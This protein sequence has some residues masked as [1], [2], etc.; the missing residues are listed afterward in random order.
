MGKFK[1]AKF[2]ITILI[3]SIV[4]V[5]I[6]SQ[7][8][9]DEGVG[10]IIPA[11]EL[12]VVGGCFRDCLD[13][14]QTGFGT[15]DC[16]EGTIA[17]EGMCVELIEATLTTFNDDGT[18]T[19]TQVLVNADG[20][21]IDPTAPTPTAPTPTEPTPTPTGEQTIT[22]NDQVF[23]V[24]Q[25]T[26]PIACWISVDADIIGEKGLVLDTEKSDVLKFA[27]RATLSLVDQPTGLPILDQGGF[28][29]ML[30]I[31][32]STNMESG[33]LDP[34]GDL[35]NFFNVFNYPSFDTALRL[36]PTKLTARVWSENVEGILGDTFNSQL[37][38]SGFDIFGATPVTIGT[39]KIPSE[40]ILIYLENGKYQSTQNIVLDGV[41]TL[42]WDTGILEV[43]K[44]RYTIPLIT[45]R[46]ENVQGEVLS[47]FNP[48]RIERDILVDKDVSGETPKMIEC[49]NDEVAVGDICA[50]SDPTLGC[51]Q[52]EVRIKGLCVEIGAS[53][54]D[55]VNPT[56]PEIFTKLSTCITSGDPSCLAGAEFLPFWIFGIGI[57]VVLGAVGQRKQ[58]DIY[59]LPRGGF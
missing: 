15:L 45:T 44:I 12:R 52:G 38:V 26:N 41:L 24:L 27:P 49:A 10:I 13:P 5:A 55:T 51:E 33:G 28:N 42:H 46:N 8:T 20:D 53:G 57:V 54:S 17:E 16:P 9:F 48:V 18:T 2:G 14:D 1:P 32:C 29:L 23:E 7:L 39:L 56:V 34:E 11:P 6:L 21:V 4:T 19:E 58:P 37:D 25:L 59:G 3:I 40:R 36:E 35:F 30:K 43:D 31:Q 22:I 47:V 50:K